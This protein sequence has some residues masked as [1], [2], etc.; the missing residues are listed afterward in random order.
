MNW[1]SLAGGVTYGD[2]LNS[3]R[4]GLIPE[5]LL[6]FQW[7]V[8]LTLDPTGARV[9]YSVRTPRA[10]GND[11]VSH[12]Y[13]R[14]L[15]SAAVTCLTEGDGNASALAWSRDG[16]QLAFSWQAAGANCRSRGHV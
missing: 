14:E 15:A 1:S 9:A 16:Q 2:E 8:E 6:K 7:V 10:A 13:V 4:R 5:D 12:V 11:Y 3:A